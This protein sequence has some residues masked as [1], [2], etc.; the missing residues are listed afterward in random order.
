MLGHLSLN[1]VP[2][3][4][5]LDD[6]SVR[7]EENDVRNAVNSVN[8]GRN[9]LSIDNLVPDYTLL[10]RGLDGVLFLIPDSDTKNIEFRTCILLLDIL[11]VWHL[12]LARSTP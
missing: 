2:A 5:P 6:G 12:S 11:D 1:V 7:T 10:L 9:P 8:V 3:E 4:I